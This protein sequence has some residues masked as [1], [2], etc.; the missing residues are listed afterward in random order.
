MKKIVSILLF[1]ALLFLTACGSAGTDTPS[2]APPVAPAEHTPPADPS[3]PAPSGEKIVFTL[4]GGDS[5]DDYPISTA[6]ARFSEQLLEESGNTLEVQ[7]FNNSILGEEID[8][9]EGVTLGTMQMARVSC[10]NMAQYVPEVSIF[11][12]PF[13]FKDQDHFWK[14]LNG[15]VGETFKQLFEENGFKLICFY[16]EGARYVLN[17]DKFVRTPEDIKGLK[18]R[19]MGAPSIQD[20]FKAFGAAPTP[21]NAGEVYT[22]LAQGVIDAAENNYATIYTM[23]WYEA[24]PYIS[25]TGHLRVPG[26]LI[27]GLN[28]WNGLS[29][30]QQ[31][32]IQKAADDSR[33]WEIGYFTEKEDEFLQLALDD[34]AQFEDLTDEERKMFADLCVPVYEQHREGKNGGI[35][36]AILAS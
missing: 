23:K 6:L 5:P 10:G 20:S 31:A 25:G 19:T 9:I 36:D 28:V 7:V 22:S 1:A 29:A 4:G 32:L 12:L 11:N 24:A 35:I 30:E 26:V 33:D 8:C 18:I 13:L 15:E 14:V 2:A 17:K 27:M 3:A 16:D 21:M 34:G